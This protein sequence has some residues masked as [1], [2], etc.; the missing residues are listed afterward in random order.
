MP[1]PG[2]QDGAVLAGG[3]WSPAAC[4]WAKEASHSFSELAIKRPK[5]VPTHPE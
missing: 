1:R 3:R 5:C 4:P 2:L